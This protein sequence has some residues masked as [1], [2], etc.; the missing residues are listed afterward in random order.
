VAQPELPA[1]IAV[2]AEDTSKVVRDCKRDRR[3]AR[4][5]SVEQIEELETH[6][7][8]LTADRWNRSNQAKVHRE[9]I[10]VA[11]LIARLC[12]AAADRDAVAGRAGLGTR[13]LIERRK[14]N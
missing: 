9:R 12:A 2:G 3:H 14:G 8:A 6:L 5:L 13:R 7:D 1:A 4:V 11:E 10:I